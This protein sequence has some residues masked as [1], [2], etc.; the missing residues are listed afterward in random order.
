M[1]NDS[2]CQ[3][4]VSKETTEIG[5]ATYHAVVLIRSGQAGDD[6]L[7][8][9]AAAAH[10]RAKFVFKVPTTLFASFD[11]IRLND[12]ARVYRL[13][14]ALFAASTRFCISNCI[15]LCVLGVLCVLCVKY[16]SAINFKR[17]G[18]IRGRRGRRDRIRGRIYEAAIDVK[19]FFRQTSA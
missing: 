16:I 15:F 1:P 14:P 8:L 4:F 2:G 6:L 19:N 5:S 17:R 7:K 9:A 13:L 11:D 10:A 12:A 3:G 18:R